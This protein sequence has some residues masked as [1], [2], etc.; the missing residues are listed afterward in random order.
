MCAALR[1]I[2]GS[3]FVFEDQTMRERYGFACGAP[4]K[5]PQVIVSPE[6]RKQLQDVLG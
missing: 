1:S 5:K 2:V 6:T 4:K 3:E